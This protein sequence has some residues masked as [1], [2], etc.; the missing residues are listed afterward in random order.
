MDGGVEDGDG[1]EGTGDGMDGDES[2]VG[3]EEV[4]GSSVTL[5]LKSLATFL[6]L[7]K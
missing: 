3:V 5:S 1:D 2:S 6:M 7:K 4:T